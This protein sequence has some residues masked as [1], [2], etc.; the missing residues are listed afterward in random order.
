MLH[1]TL[2]KLEIPFSPVSTFAHMCC[3][4][5]SRLCAVQILDRSEKFS[6]LLLRD[7][8][9]ISAVVVKV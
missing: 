1:E 3:T 6:I 4:A 5:V 8:R 9:E 2:W 7:Q